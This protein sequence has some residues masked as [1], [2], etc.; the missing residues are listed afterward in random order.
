MSH[1]R[2]LKKLILG[3]I[4]VKFDYVADIFETSFCAYRFRE[5]LKP[6]VRQ[7]HKKCSS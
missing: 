5:G 3:I 6:K 2:F 7:F 1:L 4:I